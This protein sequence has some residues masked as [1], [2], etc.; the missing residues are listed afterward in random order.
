MR[1]S[2]LAITMAAALSACGDE[3]VEDQR[4][5]EYKAA[6]PSRAALEAPAATATASTRAVGDTALFPASSVEL[7]LGVNG[8]VGWLVDTLEAVTAI[9]P[10]VFNS[11]TEEYVWGPFENDDGPGFVSVYIRKNP[12]EDDFEFTYAFVRGID[13][14][15]ANTVPVII[16][17]ATPIDGEN[18]DPSTTD[19]NEF[20]AGVLYVD[21]DAD[22]AFDE[23]FDPNYDAASHDRGRFIALFGKGPDEN[24]P[25]QINTLVVAA[26]R[27]FA[28]AND[29]GEPLS[30][31]YLYGTIEQ[32]S[33]KADFLNY[34]LPIDVTEGDDGLLE[35]TEVHLAFVNDGFGR[36]ET[37]ATGGSLASGEEVRGV[38]C[39]GD[40]FDRTYLNIATNV[41]GG[42]SYTEGVADSCTAPFNVTLVELEVPSL[43]TIPQED[44]AELARIAENGFFE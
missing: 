1:K 24:D 43:A 18:D 29:S 16:G 35:D 13:R 32:D 31:D 30:L 27:N 21:F 10:T 9:P 28:L 39:W 12:P 8:T 19:D 5:A 37:I 3:A 20:G 25:T 7:V 23:E 41:E 44:F 33:L 40:A 11:D 14:D 38:E 36:A 2:V 22:S 34:R 17:G 26:F 42:F 6:L 4:L 15:I